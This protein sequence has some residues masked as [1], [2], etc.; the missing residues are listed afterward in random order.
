MYLG[1]I[2]IGREGK[3]DQGSIELVTFVMSPE[4]NILKLVGFVISDRN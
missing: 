2:L 4:I 3:G 1:V